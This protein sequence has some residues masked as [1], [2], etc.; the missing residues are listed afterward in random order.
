MYAGGEVGNVCFARGSCSVQEAF[1]NVWVANSTDSGATWS[2]PVPLGNAVL[3]LSG[4]ATGDDNLFLPSIGVA[5]NGTIYV[6]VAQQNTSA[7]ISSM[8]GLQSDLIFVSTDDGASFPTWYTPYPS[9]TVN[10]YPL[11]DGLASSMTIMQGV[12]YMA[13]T[14][15]NCPGNGVTIFCNAL[16]AYSWSQVV[17]TSPFTG[18]GFTVSFTQ[19]GLPSASQWTASLSGNVRAARRTPH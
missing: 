8:C 19:T 7:C 17:V 13:W 3:G 16:N 14:L 15:E 1:T 9:P 10:N 6:D 11:W 18:S 12:P 2:T 4:G 5:A